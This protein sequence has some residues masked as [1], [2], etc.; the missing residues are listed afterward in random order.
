MRIE[1]LAS[2]SDG[3]IVAVIVMAN[4][5]QM[6]VNFCTARQGGIT[7]ANPDQPIF[8]G[9][10]LDVFAVRAIIGAVLAFH[11]VAAHSREQRD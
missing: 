4:G 9:E 3:S 6:K 1:S 10:D 2:Q 8:E 11:A 7:V 5:D